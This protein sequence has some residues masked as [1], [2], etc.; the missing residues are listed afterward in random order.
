LLEAFHIQ[1][2]LY[3][4]VCSE[5]CFERITVDEQKVNFKFN[6]PRR[7]LPIASYGST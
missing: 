4:N 3:L 7:E 6:A 1:E 2:I 5:L